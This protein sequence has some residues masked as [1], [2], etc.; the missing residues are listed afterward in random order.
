M[1]IPLKKIFAWLMLLALHQAWAQTAPVADMGQ[2]E[3][4]DKRDDEVKERREST[5]SK[6]SSPM[7]K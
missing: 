6:S 7:K 3:I 1:S 2:V 4:T 5:V